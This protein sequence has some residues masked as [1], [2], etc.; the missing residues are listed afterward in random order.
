MF[1]S[2]KSRLFK[3]RGMRLYD[4]ANSPAIQRC[5]NR[6]AVTKVEIISIVPCFNFL[7]LPIL[8]AKLPY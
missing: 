1:L 3:Q 2:L 4:T 8:K 5:I 7:F 6:A